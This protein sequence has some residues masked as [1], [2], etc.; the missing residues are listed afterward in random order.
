MTSRQAEE[1]VDRITKVR[2]DQPPD[3]A[4]VLAALEGPA[5]S[6]PD[7]SKHVRYGPYTMKLAVRD[8]T[9]DGVAGKVLEVKD[10]RTDLKEDTELFE[11]I[12]RLKEMAASNGCAALELADWRNIHE[13]RVFRASNDYREV[14]RPRVAGQGRAFDEPTFIAT[15]GGSGAAFDLADLGRYL[16][17]NASRGLVRIGNFQVSFRKESAFRIGSENTLTLTLV[18]ADEPGSGRYGPLL[19]AIQAEAKKHGFDAFQIEGVDDPR[20]F[21]FYEERMKYQR[22]PK[23]DDRHR[24]YFVRL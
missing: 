16:G 7:G 2:R 20:H 8:R 5:T 22:V 3:A 15:L 11:T 19:A 4:A 10:L 18:D 9:A 12:A 21:R 1:A 14:V 24:S 17:S 23:T 13:A 6:R